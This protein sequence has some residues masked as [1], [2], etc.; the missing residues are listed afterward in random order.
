VGIVVGSVE[1]EIVPTTRTF[2]QRAQAQLS[3]AG[4][5]IGRDIAARIAKPIADSVGDGVERGSWAA[6][7]KAEKQGAD[8]GGRFARELRA[9]LDRAI[10]EIPDIK[11]SADSSE[12]ERRLAT[13]RQQLQTLRDAKVGVDI[14]T[15][16]AVEEI[17]R[18]QADLADLS[19]ESPDIGVRVGAAAAHAELARLD[20]EVRRL[21]AAAPSVRVDVD[22]GAASAEL[23]ALKAGVDSL[24]GD[25]AVVDVD[26]DDHGTIDRATSGMGGLLATGL[27]LAPALIPVAA[28]ITAAFAGIGAG[29]LAGITGI[30]VAVLGLAG[31]AGAVKAIGQA[32]N[33]AG[34][35]AAQYASRQA[36]LAGATASLANAEASAADSRVRSAEQVANAQRQLATAEREAA[37]SVRDAEQALADAQRQATQAARDATA[38]Q[39]ALNGAREEARQQLQDLASQVANNAL[40]QRQAALDLQR[41]KTE[42]DA[43]A[44]D[45]ES[46]DLERQ[47]AQLTFDQARQQADD[48][49]VRQKRL[50]DQ[51]AAADKAGVNGSQVV[52]AA[53]QRIVDARQR[54]ADAQRQVAAAQTRLAET[55]VRATERIADAQRGITDAVRQQVSAQRQAAASIAQAQ[56]GVESARRG[57]AET[58]GSAVKLREAMDGLSPAGRRFAAFLAGVFLPRLRSLRDAAAEGLLP[59]V[60]AGLTALLPVLPSLARLVGA[61]AETLGRLFAEGARA[62]GSPFWQRFLQFAAAAAQKSLPILVRILGGLARAFASLTQTLF[63]LALRFGLALSGLTDRFAHLAGQ[64]GQG[65]GWQHFV[66]YVQT[67]LP[68]VGALL[69]NLVIVVAKL[70]IAFAPLGLVIAQVTTAVLAFLGSLSPAQLAVITAAMGVLVAAL[71]GG[72]GAA[73][74]AFVAIAGV[75]VYAWT[76]F[77]TFRRVV[78]DVAQAI[79]AAVRV[80]WDDVLHPIFTVLAFVV[81]RIVAP[82]V[83]A[84]WRNVFSPAFTAITI[85]VKVAWAVL[86]VIFGLMEIALK[87]LAVVAKGLGIAVTA[88]WTTVLRPVFSALGD[89]I[90]VFVAPAF[91][92]GVEAIGK[93]WDGIKEIAKAPI[94]FVVDTILNHGI[95][96]AYNKIASIFHVKPDDVQITLPKGFAGGG[97]IV[98]PGT[99]TS[100]SVIARLSD[101]EHV[102]PTRDVEAAGGHAAMFALRSAARSGTLPAFRDGGIVG[103]VKDAAR[104]AGHAA[105]DIGRGAVD[106]AKAAVEIARD[107]VKWVSGQI[108]GALDKLTG[109]LFDSPAGRIIAAIPKAVGRAAVDAVKSRFGFGGPDGTFVND[110]GPAPQSAAVGAVAARTAALLHRPGEA[111]AWGRR[112]VFESGGNWAAVNR[113]DSNWVAG[114]PSVGGAQVI[115][116]TFAQYAGPFRDRGPFLYGVSIDPLANSYAGG[117]YAVHRYGSL[118][119]VDPLVRP[120]GYDGGGALEPGWN[121]AYN[122]LGTPE[123]VLTPQQWDRLARQ[124]RDVTVNVE[125]RG[126]DLDAWDIVRAQRQQEALIPAFN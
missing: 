78:G 24:D 6:A 98:G 49:A 117:N 30:G 20:S 29:V 60:Q 112:I 45:P 22:G 33:D 119:A 71:L 4:D 42:L 52:L 100:D 36:A 56:R 94:K 72:V 96:A 17:R 50:R 34:R 91:R 38:A 8:L 105:V 51:K 40:A 92:R 26:V 120:V 102:W 18:L 85:V 84:L 87:G 104:S 39:Q 110:I 13:I 59:G 62:L 48:L 64:V 7:P 21:G 63:P 14:D 95:L 93:A 99:S 101:G 11:L 126:R 55:Q 109:E 65:S 81:G 32:Q 35:D 43:V 77:E 90:T 67:A 76:H 118:A 80:M 69:L 15:G 124:S 31:V 37:T 79:S 47:Q 125:N 113:W 27:S 114:H 115:A 103:A 106:T 108:T 70:V 5:Q 57:M 23:A 88:V 122:G 75:L 97:P 12:A 82:V 46:T 10:R 9:R 107:P 1:V 111:E 16:A 25:D 121:L 19:N 86:E 74:V 54:A 28:A 116:G 123:Q 2:R 73:V 58:A 44:G 83:I 89:Y 53:E 3:P 61:V 68:V 66:D 41:A